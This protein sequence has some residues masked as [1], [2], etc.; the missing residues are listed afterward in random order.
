MDQQTAD[1]DALVD[2]ALES[3]RF[4]RLFERLTLKLDAGERERFESQ[5]RWYLKKLEQHLSMAGFR[6][7]NLEGLAFEQGTAATP[8]NGAEFGPEE[9]VYVDQMLEPIVMGPSGLV[10]QGTVVLRSRA[11]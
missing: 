4:A 10:R 7:V 8:V 6:L 3:W 11:S 5:R 2:L 1:R 9:Q